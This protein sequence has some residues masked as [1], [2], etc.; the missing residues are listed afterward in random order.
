M[1]YLIKSHTTVRK[2]IMDEFKEQRKR[3]KAELAQ[4]KSNGQGPE[5][6]ERLDRHEESERLS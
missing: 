5:E 1:P 4:A 6:S 3:A 2:W